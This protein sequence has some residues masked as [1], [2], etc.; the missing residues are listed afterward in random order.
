MNS[1]LFVINTVSQTKD[2]DA[3]AIS[4]LGFYG[5]DKYTHRIVNLNPTSDVI[6]LFLATK[7]PSGVSVLTRVMENPRQR[8]FMLKKILYREPVKQ[9]FNA[10]IDCLG[11]STFDEFELKIVLAG[12]YEGFHG[13]DQFYETFSVTG[14]FNTHLD[15][16]KAVEKAY[17]AK[18]I[19]YVD[20]VKATES[21]VVVTVASG[22]N[23]SV[24]FLYHKD[25]TN[26][27]VPCE[28]CE[29]VV[30]IMNE[31]DTGAGTVHDIEKLAM[32]WGVW[33]GKEWSGNRLFNNPHSDYRLTSDKY[34]VYYARW[35]NSTQPQEDNTEA[36]FNIYQQ[37]AIAVPAGTDM[38]YYVQIIEALTNKEHYIVSAL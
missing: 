25:L 3:L 17:N 18:P 26:D 24:S 36:A 15:L 5:L 2:I 13:I 37:Y 38:E 1:Q 30:Q 6:N 32:Q 9:V 21:G 35:T 29:S 8:N 7:K 33:N 23:V 28:C 20:S 10:S 27:C 19:S 11:Q 4:E 14:K 34:D 22:Q 16:Y 31:G 12:A